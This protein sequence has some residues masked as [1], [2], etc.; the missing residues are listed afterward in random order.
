MNPLPQSWNTQYPQPIEAPDGSEPA[1]AAPAGGPGPPAVKVPERWLALREARPGLGQVRGSRTP[2]LKPS[3]QFSFEAQAG[4]PGS[5]PHRAAAPA[6]LSRDELMEQQVHQVAACLARDGYRIDDAEA[7][8]EAIARIGDPGLRTEAHAG[9]CG[10]LRGGSTL[11]QVDSCTEPAWVAQRIE[12]L[13]QRFAQDAQAAMALR[14]HSTLPELI[15]QPALVRARKEQAAQSFPA[16]L[17]ILVRRLDMVADPQR[18][19]G[20]WADCYTD[21]RAKD[22]THRLTLL[23]ELTSSIHL[24]PHALY[25]G[26]FDLVLQDLDRLPAP[27]RI[28]LAGQVLAT[29]PLLDQ[30]QRQDALQI[31]AGQ[32]AL[33]TP[34][35]LVAQCEWIRQGIIALGPAASRPV[36]FEQA[37]FSIFGDGL[38]EEPSLHPQEAVELIAALGRLIVHV[39]SLEERS[40]AFAMLWHGAWHFRHSLPSAIARMTEVALPAFCAQQ[41]GQAVLVGWG[42]ALPE[43][44]RQQFIERLWHCS[45]AGAGGASEVARMLGNAAHGDL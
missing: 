26:A 4:A 28:Q 27:A 19:A 9:F 11:M 43:G 34:G 17:A 13:H 40:S 3:V 23:Q 14:M 20:V 31:L 22:P 2:T 25:K 21:T 45:A 38:Q 6:P 41:P 16:L 35:K 29:L 24:L 30:T 18:R 44:E 36:L 1:L 7:L 10:L 5:S 15:G 37:A 39:G 12:L 8:L 32:L 42:A 33:P